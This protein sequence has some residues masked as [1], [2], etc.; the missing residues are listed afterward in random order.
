GGCCRSGSRLVG[1]GQPGYVVAEV[2]ANHGHDLEQAVRLVHAAKEAGADAVKLQTYTADT[3]T[4]DSDRPEFR[5]GGGTL[6]DGR[7]LHELYG[8]AYA[9]WE[10]TPRLQAVA[11]DRG[12]DLFSTAFDPTAVDFLEQLDVPV[13]K[14]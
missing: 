1:R 8:E 12:L 7:T 9:P 2:S 4:L 10:W 11:R 3:L 5:V 13:H 14:I 6:W